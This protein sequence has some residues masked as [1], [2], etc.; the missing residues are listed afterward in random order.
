MV[1]FT[2]PP[3]VRGPKNYRILGIAAML[4]TFA[5]IAG[6]ISK[7]NGYRR[8]VRK[9]VAFNPIGTGSIH[10]QSFVYSGREYLKAGKSYQ[11][12]R[13][14]DITTGK[15][16][17]LSKSARDHDIPWCTSDGSIYFST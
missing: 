17:P 13:T 14:M 9:T 1:L 11:Q 12:I 2:V 6:D 7:V 16:T 15:S 3:V 10:G 8:L 5:L 4:F